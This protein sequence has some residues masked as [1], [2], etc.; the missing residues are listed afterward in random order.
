MLQVTRAVFVLVPEGTVLQNGGKV[1][2]GIEREGEMVIRVAQG[3]AS[4]VL[5][6]Q[7]DAAH[8][9][10][11][12]NGLWAQ[13]WD[14]DEGRL[15]RCAEAPQRHVATASVTLV[16][17]DRLPAGKAC[18][19]IERDGEFCWLIAEGHMSELARQEFETLLRFIVG[20]GL[21]I[22]RWRD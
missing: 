20:N 13:E 22:Q 2:D 8:E 16:P 21:W 1:L 15:A 18:M 11:V 19:A 3:H 5:C 9:H 6:Q 7:M 17:A 14:G 12:G 4:H 10:I